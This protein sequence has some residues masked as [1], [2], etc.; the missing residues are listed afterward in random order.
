MKGSCDAGDACDL[1]HD[2]AA[3]RTPVCLHFTKGNCSNA[4]CRYIH[5]RVSPS[6]PVCRAFGIYGYCEKGATCA[7]RHVHECPDFSNTGVCNTKGCKL[8]HRLKA[9]VIRK[10]AAK[11][12]ADEGSSDLSSDDEGDEIDSDDVDSDAIEE[13]FFGEG[14]KDEDIPMQQDFVHF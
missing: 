1:S 10:N 14:E 11:A 9:S 7:D 5:V 6:A 2:L 13:E 8:P 4:N 3:E 12:D